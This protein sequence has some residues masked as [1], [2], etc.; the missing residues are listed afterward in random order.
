MS[1]NGNE[2]KGQKGICCVLK[3]FEAEGVRHMLY[4]IMQRRSCQ[5]TKLHN[6]Q[7]TYNTSGDLPYYNQL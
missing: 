4:N 1:E 6:I 3:R 5:L 7:S 2:G